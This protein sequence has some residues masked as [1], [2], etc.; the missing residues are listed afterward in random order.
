MKTRLKSLLILAGMVC[1]LSTSLSADYGQSRDP[2]NPCPPKKPD[3][4]AC[5]PE[6]VCCDEVLDR[7][8][9]MDE[10][11]K[12]REITPMAGPRVACGADLFITADFIYW[13]TRMDGMGYAV[14][15]V[16]S[17]AVVPGKGDVKQV[18]FSWDPGFKVGL[19]YNFEHDGWDIYAEYTWLRPGESASTSNAAGTLR[20][21]WTDSGDLRDDTGNI[22]A[23]I[24]NAS[25]SWDFDFNVVDL[26]LGRNY[27]ISH[28]LTLRPFFG[29]KGTWQDH[30]FV[31]RYTFS[32]TERRKTTIDQDSWA[33]G[34]RTGLNTVWYFNQYFGIYGDF[35][36]AALW[37]ECDVDRKDER[38][39]VDANGGE[40]AT[41]RNF[42][43]NDRY[44]MKSVF[45]I[46]M[47]LELD[48]WFSDDAFHLGTKAGWEMQ[49][50]PNQNQF[51]RWLEEA[52]HGDL[53]FMGFTL[54]VRFDF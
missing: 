7:M 29:L 12:Y 6:P 23:V 46:A 42:T 4:C 14:S 47:G 19:G 36:L 13:T 21:M 39:A 22:N 25:A 10:C 20:P 51:F 15:G 27:F 26:S 33:V 5:P 40:T 9:V 31:A 17:A 3:P 32:D 8:R 24:T 45:E 52:N 49:Y 48:F 11:K 50:W 28:Y 30:A 38:I 18:D 44:G 37:G 54:K 35:S 53:Y 41:T 1:C 2:C 43:E 16:G 34:L